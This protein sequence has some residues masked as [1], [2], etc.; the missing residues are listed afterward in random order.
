MKKF[1]YIL[2]LTSCL[3]LSAFSHELSGSAKVIDGDTIEV[4]GTV[5][6]LLGI[7][8]AETAQRCVTSSKKIVRPGE[9]ASNRMESLVKNGVTCSGTEYDAFNR[10]LA[11]CTT[12]AGQNVNRILVQE[13]LAWAFIKYSKQYVAEENAARSSQLGVWQLACEEPW[14]FREKRWKVAEQKAPNGC[15]IKGNISNNGHIYH[16]PWSRHYTVTSIDLSR[17]ERWFCSEKEALDAGWRAPI[18]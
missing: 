1:G 4:Q 14:V 17:G 7:D 10:L 12:S 9:T 8:A 11:N 2:L 13:G 18:R 15:P 6:R 3:P 5:V 16:T